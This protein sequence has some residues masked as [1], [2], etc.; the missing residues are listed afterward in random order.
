MPDDA[1]P[2]SGRLLNVPNVLSGARLIGSLAMFFLATT[3]QSRLFLC[4]FVGLAITDW[5]DG[6]LAILLHQRTEFGARLDSAADAMLYTAMM[7]GIVWLQGEFVRRHWIWLAAA[8]AS[9]AVTSLAGLV[10]FGRIPSYHTRGAK[11]SAYLVFVSVLGIFLNWADWLF[12]TAAIAVI[13][14]NLEAT[15]ITLLLSEWRVDVS[16]VMNVAHHPGESS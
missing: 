1:G 4:F 10:K 7:F 8:L 6:K 9:Y 5:L 12:Y 2:S 15:L 13:V 16:S 14:T 3:G 11:I